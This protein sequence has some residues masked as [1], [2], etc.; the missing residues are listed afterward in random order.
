[1]GGYAIIKKKAKYRVDGTYF[2]KTSFV[3][4][5]LKAKL[6]EKEM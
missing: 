5:P 1:V 4:F 6:T 2:L 3:T